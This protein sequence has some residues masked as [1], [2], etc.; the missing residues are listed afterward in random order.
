MTR[1]IGQRYSP[2][3]PLVGRLDMRRAL[4]LPGR[5]L[6]AFD[7]RSRTRGLSTSSSISLTVKTVRAYSAVPDDQN[8]VLRR[9]ADVWQAT[10]P[11]ADGSPEPG[12]RR[13]LDLPDAPP[14]ER[15]STAVVEVAAGFHR[16]FVA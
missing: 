13:C 11:A 10:P 3:E 4:G 7:G 9:L 14:P 12:L 6:A 15:V 16:A 2:T 1:A 5:R 8:L